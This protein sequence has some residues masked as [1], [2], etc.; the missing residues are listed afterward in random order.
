MGRTR[1]SLFLV[2]LTTLLTV[3]IS[4]VAGT[5]DEI[6]MLSRSGSLGLAMRLLDRYQPPVSDVDSWIQ[7]ERERLNLYDRTGKLDQLIEHITGMKDQI[8]QN[9]ARWLLLQAVHAYLA[10]GDGKGAR[11]LLIELIW[12][13]HGP[14]NKNDAL[15]IRRLLVRSLLYEGQAE[16]ALIVV[17]QYQKEY[18]AVMEQSGNEE[19]I[20]DQATVYLLTGHLDKAQELLMGVVGYGLAPLKY[21][22]A[23]RQKNMDAEHVLR[24]CR[25]AL[26]SDGASE[27]APF[28]WA[29]IAE[30]ADA[31][32]HGLE[33]AHALE[34]SLILLGTQ[35]FIKG[36]F[37]MDADRLWEVYRNLKPSLARVL[38]V[39]LDAKDSVWIDVVQK[40]E[41][42]N[43]FYARF[44]Y[45][46]LAMESRDP[47]VRDQA[48]GLFA[49][50]VLRLSDG[51]R[52]LQALYLHARHFP[53]TADIPARVRHIMIGQAINE[54]DTP[55]AS[56]LMKGLWQAPKGVAELDWKL[57][58]ARVHI[59][60]D[61]HQQGTEVILGLLKDINNFSNEQLDRLLQ[62]LFD[63]Q[64]I[65]EH[66]TVIPLFEIVHNRTSDTQ[67]KREI[68]FWIAE[69]MQEL[70]NYDEAA[71]Y[72]LKSATFTDEK[73]MDL[74][75]QSARFKAA[76]MLTLA[77]LPLDA[78][79]I[80]QELLKVTT[81]SGQRS[82]L[83][84]NIQQLAYRGQ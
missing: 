56:R 71:R 68:L 62:V 26:A 28:Y 54:A 50:S 82:H 48:H 13:F 41:K 25:Q 17:E 21:L 7:W 72:Y 74:W 69:S 46:M 73:A 80:Y 5:L 8:P 9:H 33:R 6:S 19:W 84:R 11:R 79:K 77:G 47:Q 76:E 35:P 23:L 59:M 39:A 10:K 81:D 3:P 12:G 63:L 61:Q 31:L 53:D 45:A 60:A 22:V 30:A 83:E 40:Q 15:R 58:R 36:L 2:F 20:H 43:P 32:G 66:R 65:G 1:R 52:L 44:V 34:Q 70:K 55:L 24:V 29:I 37:A 16:D 64:A 4:S 49:T 75:A 38:G 27:T 67:R 57:R 14:L 18:G 78:R 51:D 42:K